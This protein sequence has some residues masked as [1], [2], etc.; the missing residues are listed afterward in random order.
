MRIYSEDKLAKGGEDQPRRLFLQAL[1]MHN[2]IAASATLSLYTAALL[3]CMIM[4]MQGH[5]Q[6][7][8]QGVS[9]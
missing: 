7:L 4:I 3:P 2:F 1:N 6:D 8:I 9:K 5:T